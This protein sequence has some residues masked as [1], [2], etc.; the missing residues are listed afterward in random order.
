MKQKYV[1]YIV[2]L[3]F[4][5][6]LILRIFTHFLWAHIVSIKLN[7]LKEGRFHV[8]L[9]NVSIL[10]SSN[11]FSFY[12]RI[13]VPCVTLLIHSLAARPLQLRARGFSDHHTTPFS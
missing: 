12:P 9:D 13:H 2:A 6:S 11:R 5:I 3:V 7:Y 4:Q 8:S 1:N 10:A